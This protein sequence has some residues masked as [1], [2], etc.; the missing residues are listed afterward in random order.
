MIFEIVGF[1]S[2]ADDLKYQQD[3]PLSLEQLKAIMGWDCDSESADDWQLT[4]QQVME[5]QKLCPFQLPVDLE[6]Y[7]SSYVKN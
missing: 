4:E 1:T 3:I 2:S 5:I 7:L 6:L